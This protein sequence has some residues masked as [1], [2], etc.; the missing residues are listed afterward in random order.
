[1]SYDKKIGFDLAQRPWERS[2]IESMGVTPINLDMKSRLPKE[3]KE[4]EPKLLLPRPKSFE[5]V[6]ALILSSAN[7]FMIPGQLW[8]EKE[9]LTSI[10]LDRKTIGGFPMADLTR[11]GYSLRFRFEQNPYTGEIKQRDLNEKTALANA[12]LI[13]GCADRDEREI[14]VPLD[15]TIEQ[16]YS[17]FISKYNILQ[18]PSFCSNIPYNELSC[19]AGY[20]AARTEF[21]F[22]VRHP[23][24]PVLFVFEGCEDIFD[25]LHGDMSRATVE[26]LCEFEF[27]PKQMWGELPDWAQS[28]DG[29]KAFLYSSMTSIRDTIHARVAGSEINSF[30][31]A[32]IAQNHLVAEYGFERL[33]MQQLGLTDLFSNRTP[34]GYQDDFTAVQYSLMMSQSLEE[35]LQD[36]MQGI[37]QR[38][39]QLHNAKLSNNEG[40]QKPDFAHIGSGAYQLGFN[41]NVRQMS[42]PVAKLNFNG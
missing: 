23:E 38:S 31:K 42:R 7:S 28:P 34:I 41:D 13:G 40:S 35:T 11:N 27:E 12:N 32:E 16:G 22:A 39:A 9:P 19:Y 25:T 37:F 30:S 18:D 6:R 29:F 10:L 20:I 4:P 3:S 26:R 24:Y 21:G 2:M 17:N 36:N 8:E 33:P 1:M 5:A 14:E 15:M